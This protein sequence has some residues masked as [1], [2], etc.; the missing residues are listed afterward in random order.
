MYITDLACI[1]P[2][3]TYT[4]EFLS[5]NLVPNA[6][7][8][9]SALE[10]DYKGIIAPSLLRRM[11]KALRMGVGAGALLLNRNT[12]PDGIVLGTAYGGL[13][14]CLK[15]LNQIV[16]FN[17][18]TLSPTNFV[19]ST[20][21]NIA[22]QLSLMSG[23]S[24]YN[25]THVHKGHAFEAALIDALLFLE[26]NANSTLLVGAAEEIS[27]YNYSIDDQAG[28]YKKEETNSDS[29]LQS[30]TSGTVC[31][32]GA[33][34]FMVN[35]TDQL[36]YFARIRDVVMLNNPAPEELMVAVK[37]LLH[38]HGY[39]PSDIQCLVAGYNGDIRND[40]WYDELT[41][42]LFSHIR[43]LSFKHWTGDYPTASAFAVWL[44]CHILKGNAPHICPQPAGPVLIYN[45]YLGIQHSIILLDTK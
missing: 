5:G 20:P 9:Y 45:H 12:K 25:S 21:N 37:S 38:N 42:S 3:P 2:Q 33:A 14:H 11:A 34:M 29:L 22:S 13:D 10:P 15:F 44:G 17:E 32:E 23:N 36:P 41:Q 1:S 43:P 39:Q 18:S 40:Y 28:I 24:G 6:G 27:A 16:D 26:E 19:Q 8:R 35:S 4:D 31:G 30:G 7:T